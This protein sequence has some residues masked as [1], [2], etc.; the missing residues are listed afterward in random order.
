MVLHVHYTKWGGNETNTS[1]TSNN[2]LSRAVECFFKSLNPTPECL[3]TVT[4]YFRTD[5]YQNQTIQ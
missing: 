3:F 4:N 2:I 5:K 1:D